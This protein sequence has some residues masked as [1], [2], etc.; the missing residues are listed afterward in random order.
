MLSEG[1]RRVPVTFGGKGWEEWGKEEGEN[2]VPP[3]EGLWH[4]GISLSALSFIPRA[5]LDQES[6]P[7]PT[8]HCQPVAIQPL[9]VQSRASEFADTVYQAEVRTWDRRV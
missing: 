4:P 2:A 3:G 9:L 8:P 5:E 6:C 1:V 7:R